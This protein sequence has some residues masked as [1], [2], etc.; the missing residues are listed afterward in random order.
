MLLFLSL[1]GRVFFY[2]QCWLFLFEKVVGLFFFQL[3]PLSW[4]FHSAMGAGLEVKWLSNKK[5]SKGY[6]STQNTSLNFFD[7]DNVDLHNTSY[8]NM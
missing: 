3:S 1:K 5:K 6:I 7:D 2:L 4:D 8:I